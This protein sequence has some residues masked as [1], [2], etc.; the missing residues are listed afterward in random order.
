MITAIVLA[1]GSGRRMNLGYNKQYLKLRDKEVLAYTL[2]AFQDNKSI[3]SIIVVS[4]KDEIDL[5]RKTIIG[6]YNFTKVSNIIVGGETRQESVYNGLKACKNCN[7]A[8]IH[9]GARPFVKGEYID[10][11]VE[12]AKKEKSA[13]LAVKVKDTIKMGE[14]GIFTST[15]D[16][17]KLYSVQTPQVFKYELILKAYE[18]AKKNG[19]CGTD[20]ASLVELLG[21]KVNI[22]LGDY[23]NIKITTIEDKYIGE[24]II[25]CM[26]E[27]KCE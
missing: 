16:R 7:I 24:A 10:E 20:D 4:H 17:G 1:A 11:C 2:E 15:L 19:L 23:F 22:V 18:N 6:K 8:V 14:E 3:D 5:L 12:L 9:D 27:G 25:N 13:V 21:E 26:E